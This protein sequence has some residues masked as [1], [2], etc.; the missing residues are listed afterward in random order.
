MAELILP[1]IIEAYLQLGAQTA[2]GAK[3]LT[4]GQQLSYSSAAPCASIFVQTSPYQGYG[5]VQCS[6]TP[7][8]LE[9]LVGKTVTSLKLKLFLTYGRNT[10]GVFGVGDA[11]SRVLPI[12]F[13]QMPA[14]LATFSSVSDGAT[15]IVDLPPQLKQKY[16]LWVTN[17][18]FVQIQSIYNFPTNDYFSGQEAQL[19]VQ[20]QD[21]GGGGGGSVGGSLLDMAK[22]WTLNDDGEQ[23]QKPNS[24][25]VSLL[26]GPGGTEVTERVAATFTLS[27]ATATL[28][29]PIT[30]AAATSAYTVGAVA[31]WSDAGIKVAEVPCTQVQVRQGDQPKLSQLSITLTALSVADKVMQ[32]V[33]GSTPVGQNFPDISSATRY[34]KLLLRG[35]LGMLLPGNMQSTFLNAANTTQMQ[36]DQMPGSLVVRRYELKDSFDNLLYSKDVNIPVASGYRVVVSVGGLHA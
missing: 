29:A 19:V 21:A 22:A 18:S 12:K 8:G 23:V 13:S 5:Y 4:D 31:V 7:I 27:G 24:L 30:F 34:R 15:I 16:V 1:C 17:P 35:D 20:Y 11:S 36:S 2:D 32:C 26:S 10:T 28:A 9:Q 3:E 14:P 6:V 33:F 25:T